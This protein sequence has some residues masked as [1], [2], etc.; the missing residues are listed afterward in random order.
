MPKTALVTGASRGIG[1]AVEVEQMF[2]ETV[3][4]FGSVDVVVNNSGI[5]PLSPIGKGDAALFDKVIQ[6]NLRGT[7]LVMAQAAQRL[8][9]GGRFIAFSSSVLARSFPMALISLQRP[10][11]RAWST[12]LRMKCAAETSP[13][14]PWRPD[15]S[16]RSCS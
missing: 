7:F 11:S 4:A 16:A 15:L 2:D 6:T 10:E 8:A 5:M 3:K 13:S 9:G 14:T 12:C 1:N